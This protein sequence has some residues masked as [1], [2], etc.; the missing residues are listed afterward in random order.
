MAAPSPPT[1]NGYPFA[2]YPGDYLFSH[3]GFE[4][5]PPG[6]GRNSYPPPQQVPPVDLPM[7]PQNPNG[8]PPHMAAMMQPG[9]APVGQIPPSP[10]M[11]NS[12]P[13]GHASPQDAK[14]LR[15]MMQMLAKMQ[16]MMKDVA[17]RQEQ[18]LDRMSV[19]EQRGMLLPSP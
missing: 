12:M 15:H 16:N 3:H 13:T 11:H 2:T 18:I 14:M 6:H 1:G 9:G 7:M 8:Y 19:L 17:E 10:I 4:T 5:P